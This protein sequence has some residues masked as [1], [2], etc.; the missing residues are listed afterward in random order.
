MSLLVPL[1]VPGGPEL[2]I[3]FIL[4]LFLAVPALLVVAVIVYLLRRQPSGPDD[5]VADLE[6]RVD[7]LETR[8]EDDN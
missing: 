1:Q 3:I 5:R 7:E 6:Q 2:L 8:L 4:F